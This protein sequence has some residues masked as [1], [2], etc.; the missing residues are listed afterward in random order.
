MSFSFKKH[1]P[2]AGI[3]CLAPGLLPFNEPHIWG[4]L[5]WLM[6]GAKGMKGLDWFDLFLHGLPWVYLAS[7]ILL[8]G[9]SQLAKIRR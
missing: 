8:F 9:W 3:L 5:K 1:F 4:K 7:L 6:G 2:I